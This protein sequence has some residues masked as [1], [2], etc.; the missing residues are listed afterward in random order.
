MTED[1]NNEGHKNMKKLLLIAGL[2][3]VS[4]CAKAPEDIAA[5]SMD[6][7]QYSRYSCTQLKQSELTLNQ[8]LENLSAKQNSAKTGDA[9]GVFLLGLP[10]SSMSGNDQETGIAVTKGKIQAVEAEM[11]KKKC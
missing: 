9:W 3:I 11:L 10:V 6:D 2:L 5:V 1:F 4:A 7:G 8:E